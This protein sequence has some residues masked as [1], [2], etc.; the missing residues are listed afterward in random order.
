MILIAANTGDLWRYRVNDSTW[1]WMGGSQGAAP[2]VYGPLG[3]ANSTY[4]PG[5]RHLTGFF[6][7]YVSQE[8][9]M[10]GGYGYST[11]ATQGTPVS[12]YLTRLRFFWG[13]LQLF[14]VSS[15]DLN[16][17]WR[18]RM[19]DNTWAWMGG[20]N[21][22]SPPTVYGTLGV[23]D[24][25]NMPGGRG[26]VSFAVDPVRAKA[27]MFGGA[28]NPLGTLKKTQKKNLRSRK[29]IKIRAF[30]RFVPVTNVLIRF[31]Y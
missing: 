20:Q 19:S 7:D 5:W 2:G 17:V 15:G 28:V 13:V 23:A 12:A 21:V 4:S 27:F 14:H 25:S 9:W 16:E 6:Y 3:I 29:E 8:L 30:D 26:W 24:P 1:T 10:F 31:S 18:Y 22:V 11:N